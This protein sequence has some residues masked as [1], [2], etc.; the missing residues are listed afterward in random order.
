M[1]RKQAGPQE[2]NHSASVVAALPG[3]RMAATFHAAARG[4]AEARLRAM[5]K[6]PR[7]LRPALN[8]YIMSG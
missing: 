6:T 7:S 8:F 4:S 2:V 3:V 5:L 1:D